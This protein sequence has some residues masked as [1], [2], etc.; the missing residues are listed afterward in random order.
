L[1]LSSLKKRASEYATRRAVKKENQVAWLLRAIT[2]IDL[3][4][5]A[6]DDTESNVQRLV[7]KAA[8]PIRHD[9]LKSLGFNE[10]GEKNSFLNYF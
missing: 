4:T 8:Y 5:L 7:S 9:L 6:G 2:C 1:N 3:T 10:T